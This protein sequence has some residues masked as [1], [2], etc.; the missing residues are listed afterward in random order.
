MSVNAKMTS[1]ANEIRELSGTTDPMGLDDMA[2]N[3]NVANDEIDLQAEKLTQVLASL[4]GKGSGEGGVLLQ[5]KTVSPS[6]T[7][8]TVAPD[9]GYGGLSV[10]TVD[11]MPVVEQ[12]VPRIV[13]DDNDGVISASAKQSAGYVQGGTTQAHMTLLIKGA[14][15][16][17][18]TE[19]SQIAVRKGYYTTGAITVGAI[20]SSYVKPTSTKNATTYTP[21][22]SDQ[23]IEAG[24]YCS[25]AQTIE[26]D[27][28]LIAENIKKNTS[29]F[30]I[31]GTYDG[32]VALTNI[33]SGTIVY[34]TDQ[35]MTNT[36]PVEILHNLGVIP[37]VIRFKMASLGTDVT[38]SDFAT[39]VAVLTNDGNTCMVVTTR[40]AATN[41]NGPANTHITLDG[42]DYKW[43]TKKVY[44]F[45][46]SETYV[47]YIRAGIEYSWIAYG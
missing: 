28:N 10:V 14:E 7:V 29:I 2:E 1:V 16:I 41:Y 17:V 36:Q 27:G 47:S 18:P 32:P 31:T 35:E 12:A 15:T 23:T 3:I 4:V 38:T 30:G 5:E 21:T 22:T 24:T 45:S 43:T 34:N 26:G 40:K 44:I 25:G 37:K 19:E 8:Q 6:T 11:A 46:G 33:G 9:A 13:L 39:G 42:T 20:P